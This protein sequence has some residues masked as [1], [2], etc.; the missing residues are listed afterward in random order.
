MDFVDW[1]EQVQLQSRI[2]LGL[3]FEVEFGR[4]RAETL[5]ELGDSPTA[6]IDRLMEKY[7]LMDLTDHDFRMS[8][9]HERFTWDGRHIPKR[10]SQ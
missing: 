3:E 6:A 7:N 8:F 5:F 10:F 2:R 1:Y 4:D 9:S